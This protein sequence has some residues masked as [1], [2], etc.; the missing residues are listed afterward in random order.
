MQHQF[1][2]DKFRLPS[3]GPS[4]PNQG[5]TQYILRWLSR[6][7]V[8][9]GGKLGDTK[10]VLSQRLTVWLRPVVEAGRGGDASDASGEDAADQKPRKLR[11]TLVARTGGAA[12][13]PVDAYVR[14]NRREVPLV[15]C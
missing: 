4:D 2:V 10:E 15:A 9:M 7:G 1:G 11:R 8:H 6:T 12:P 5:Q 13:V 3:T 14:L